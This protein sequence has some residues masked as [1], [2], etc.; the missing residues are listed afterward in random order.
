MFTAGHV[1]FSDK[2][3][4]RAVKVIVTPGLTS[5]YPGYSVEALDVRYPPS[6]QSSLKEPWDYGAVILRDRVTF[7]NFGIIPLF[8]AS[9]SY[10]NSMVPSGRR[11]V[12]A[13]YPDAHKGQMWSCKDFVSDCDA[14]TVRHKVRT[15]GGDSGAPLL[16]ID[17]A[18]AVHSGWLTDTSF[19]VGRR[20]TS[21]V[22]GQ[23]NSWIAEAARL[24]S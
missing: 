7:A 13:G 12:I 3:F 16:T 23:A 1:V 19:N 20:V 15:W 10:L 14:T 4:G 18:I 17:G 22:V 21:E 11:V 24:T 8:S 5:Q 2:G 6:W 9:D